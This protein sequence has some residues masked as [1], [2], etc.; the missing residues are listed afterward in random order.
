MVKLAPLENS[1]VNLSGKRYDSEF[2]NLVQIHHDAI[3]FDERTLFLNDRE[4]K[5][6]NAQPLAVNHNG[7][8]VLEQEGVLGIVCDLPISE[9]Q[10][11]HV[12][13]HEL[14][15]P[16]TIQGMLSNYRGYNAEA[17]PVLLMADAKV[18][19]QQFVDQH[20]P[21]AVYKAQASQALYYDGDAAATLLKMFEA[22]DHLY[23][24]DG[25][26]RL[27][28]TALSGFKQNVL[29][30]VVCFKDIKILPI[31]RQLTR[32]SE[33]RFQTSLQFIQR[34]F[35]VEA[36]VDY[37]EPANIPGTVVMYRGPHAWRIHL[38]KLDADGFWN[39]D[40]Y[41]LNTQ[42]IQQAFR[43]FDDQRYI[44]YLS[45]QQLHHRHTSKD[46]VFFQV[47]PVSKESFVAS[48]AENNILPPKS[49][50]MWPKAPS[51]FIMSRYQ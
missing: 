10:Q 38:I 51:M 34:K 1:Y 33:S 39:N 24:G 25:H 43:I 41:R 3:R 30:Y 36:L 50:W 17:A 20:Q 7:V 42:I 32:I 4:K 21:K 26:H 18:Q 49:T 35:N 22:T 40:I 15:L 6:L 44:N 11:Q 45:D 8:Y 2:I 23:V 47:S 9:Y 46:A 28:S 5:Q 27:Y 48:A 19:L 12:K 16:D 14:V 31:H 29:A 13:N 37:D